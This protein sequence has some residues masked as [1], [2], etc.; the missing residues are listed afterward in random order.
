MLLGGHADYLNL[1]PSDIGALGF[2]FALSVWQVV[3]AAPVFGWE[4]RRGGRG[5]FGIDLY[6][7]GNVTG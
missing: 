4:L 3:F 2:A 1:R 7:A 6:P 5:I